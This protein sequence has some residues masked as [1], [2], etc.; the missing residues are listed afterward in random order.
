MNFRR[1]PTLIIGAI[2]TVL[3]LVAGYGL[4]FLSPDQAGLIIVVLNAALGVWNALKVRPIGPAAFTYFIGAVATLIATYGVEW[5]QSQIS[6]VNAVVLA[7]LALIFR[8]QVTPAATAN[9]EA[10]RGRSG[11]SPY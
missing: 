3:T 7:L 5:T 1:E 6:N 2:G 8:G 9:A 10:V 4:D 11:P